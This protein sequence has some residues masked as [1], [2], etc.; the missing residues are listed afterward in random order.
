MVEGATSYSS[1]VSQ[2]DAYPQM[3]NVSLAVA[4]V[5]TWQRAN[6]PD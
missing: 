2:R 4:S 5:Q 3:V 1:A 6:C